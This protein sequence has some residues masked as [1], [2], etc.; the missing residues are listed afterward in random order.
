[1]QTSPGWY[2]SVGGSSL[3]DRRVMGSIPG[4]GTYPG[5]GVQSPFGAHIRKKPINVSLS[6]SLSLPFFLNAMKTKYPWGRDKKKEKKCRQKASTGLITKFVPQ[7]PTTSKA[8]R[9]V[10]WIF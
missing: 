8:F 6:L 10:F 5:C 3:V 7:S 1:M 4:Q 9:M 2:G